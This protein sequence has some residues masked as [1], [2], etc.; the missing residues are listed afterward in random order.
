MPLRMDGGVLR[1]RRRRGPTAPGRPTLTRRP[2]G[3]PLG[4]LGSK[5]RALRGDSRR[6]EVGTGVGAATSA[7]WRRSA[8]GACA[9]SR[10]G[11]VNACARA[12]AWVRTCAGCARA[13]GAQH[14]LRFG[15]GRRG[16]ARQSA[17]RSTVR[18]H[19]RRWTRRPHS[20]ASTRVRKRRPV[21]R[22]ALAGQVGGAPFPALAC[23]KRSTTGKPWRRGRTG[24]RPRGPTQ[25]KKPRFGLA[26]G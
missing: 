17:L 15:A 3:A 26:P 16:A 4:L 21:V 20:G 23:V 18:R 22:R 13:Q 24:A 14:R 8:G 9:L 19:G 6:G 10:R 1:L 12:C 2:H 7:W 5:G 25:E 11:R